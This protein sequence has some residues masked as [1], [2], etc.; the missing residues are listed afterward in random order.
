M[1]VYTVS[2]QRSRA[3]IGVRLAS[4]EVCGQQ[5]S[6]CKLLKRLVETRNPEAKTL[7]PKPR[8]PKPGTLLMK[9]LTT[10]WFLVGSGG[11]DPYSS[12]YIIT[13]SSPHNQFP[14]SRPRTRQTREW[15]RRRKAQPAH[16]R[17]R[18]RDSGEDL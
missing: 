9:R 12:L 13:N 18:P 14:Y 2:L 15:H 4:D 11:R 10:V 8:N 7:N 16:P 6:V 1:P 3:H 17:V 5:A